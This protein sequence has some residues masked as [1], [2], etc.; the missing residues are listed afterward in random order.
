MRPE[1]VV[2]VVVGVVASCR[3]RSLAADDASV[4]VADRTAA[5]K[6][7]SKFAIYQS[8]WQRRFA[9]RAQHSAICPSNADWNG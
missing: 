5:D 9:A 1:Y 2:H 3:Q 4:A 8:A 6:K 7:K